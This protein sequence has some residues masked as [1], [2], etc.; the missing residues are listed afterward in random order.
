MTRDLS[1][2]RSLPTLRLR[3]AAMLVGVCAKTFER[4]VLSELKVIEVGRQRLVT[5]ASLR[6][7]LGEEVQEIQIVGGVSGL[8][9]AGMGVVMVKDCGHTGTGMTVFPVG[10]DSLML[11]SR[12][13]AVVTQPWHDQLRETSDALAEA[14]RENAELRADAEIGKRWR[15]NSSLE[16]WF[17]FTHE[18]LESLKELIEDKTALVTAWRNLVM[19]VNRHLEEEM[20]AHDKVQASLAEA[21]RERDEARM[22]RDHWETKHGAEKERRLAAEADN[23]E[24]L[25]LLGRYKDLTEALRRRVEYQGPQWWCLSA[26]LDSFDEADTAIREA[27]R[28]E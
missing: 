20:A 18:E 17:P 27:R 3:E 24:L 26:L 19:S 22:A 5:V 16:E 21:Q 14:Q 10:E 12:C 28:G 15:S 13:H 7:W 2:W 11:C 23:E 6:K 9:V 8:G 4:E 1:A 25:E